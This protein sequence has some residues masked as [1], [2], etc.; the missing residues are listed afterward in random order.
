MK[1]LRL[2]ILSLLQYYCCNYMDCY[3]LGHEFLPIQINESQKKKEWLKVNSLVC[4]I[5]VELKPEGVLLYWEKKTEI[6]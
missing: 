3:L 1:V 5:E 6:R 2:Q 4:E